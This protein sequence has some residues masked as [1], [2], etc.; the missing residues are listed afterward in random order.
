M[1]PC[2][3][4]G[5]YCDIDHI[6]T[7]GELQFIPIPV[8]GDDVGFYVCKKCMAKIAEFVESK[9]TKSGFEI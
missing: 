2:Y 6:A 9:T 5:K 4:C 7:R 1:Q 8:S 3:M